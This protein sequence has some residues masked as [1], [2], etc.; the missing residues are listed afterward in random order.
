MRPRARWTAIAI[1]LAAL[2]AAIGMCA[3]TWTRDA[4]RRD[5][6]TTTTTIS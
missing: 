6:W 2:V 5:G 1:V 3:M 4:A